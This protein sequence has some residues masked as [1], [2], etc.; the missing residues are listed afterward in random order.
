MADNNQ[1]RLGIGNT[2][3]SFEQ[4][5]QIFPGLDTPDKKDEPNSGFQSGWEASA[6]NGL[7][8][9]AASYRDARLG[10]VVSASNF[11]LAVI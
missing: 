4:Q 2:S 5:S 11:I 8:N 1:A 9:A 10:D 6:K 3:E 7:T